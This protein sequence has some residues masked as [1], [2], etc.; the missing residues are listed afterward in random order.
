MIRRI[1]ALAILFAA[2][3]AALAAQC[4]NKFVAR[5]EG[6]HQSL[7]LLTGMLTFQEAKKLATDIQA[8]DVPPIEWVDEKGK[9]IARQFGELKVVRPMPVGCDGRASGVILSVYL[10]T[11]Q[12][13]TKQMS[14][15]LSPDNIVVFQ[16]Q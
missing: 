5:R 9:A 1:A 13:P 15:R 6:Q 7:T 10:M 16:Q 3:D 14:V 8:G 4:V 2:A 12:P 11:V